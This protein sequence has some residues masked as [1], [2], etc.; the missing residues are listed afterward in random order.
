[1]PF[2]FS[3]YSSAE[4][5]GHLAAVSGVDGI[6]VLLDTNRAHRTCRCR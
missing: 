4:L 5:G 1:M 3:S 6:V 2:D